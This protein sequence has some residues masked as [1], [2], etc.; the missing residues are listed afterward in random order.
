MRAA[1]AF[2]VYGPTVGDQAVS[3]TA[4]N[5]GSVNV[6]LLGCQ[7]RIKGSEDTLAPLT[8]VV[9]TPTNLPT[10]LEPGAHW[11]GM[12]DVESIRQTLRSHVGAP[13]AGTGRHDQ[14]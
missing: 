7:L 10:P 9:Q 14:R 3:I 1:F 4:T 2:P 5:T 12:V 13:A 8:W 6:T 11:N